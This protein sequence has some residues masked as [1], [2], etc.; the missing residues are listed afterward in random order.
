VDRD[1]C[2]KEWR[3]ETGMLRLAVVGL[4]LAL[5]LTTTVYA[6]DWYEGASCVKDEC[7]LDQCQKSKGSPA[8]MYQGLKKMGEAPRLVDIGSE[9]VDVEVGKLTWMLFRTVESCR[10][11]ADEVRRK[12]EAEK[13]KEN[14]R[15]EKYR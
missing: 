13:Q 9:R 6:A 1:N 3:R 10:K 14:E 8:D 5:S 4:I 15:L 12:A 11:F 2:E 7:N